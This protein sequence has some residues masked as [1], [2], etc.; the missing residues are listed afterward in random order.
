[1]PT[2]ERPGRDCTGAL[3]SFRPAS[4]YRPAGR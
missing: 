2:H 1:M 4:G 3:R